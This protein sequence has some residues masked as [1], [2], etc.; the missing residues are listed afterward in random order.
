ME[1]KLG[2]GKVLVAIL[3][4]DGVQGV[5]FQ[6]LQ[7]AHSIGLTSIIWEKTTY[8]LREEDVVIWISKKESLDVVIDKLSE[9]RYVFVEAERKVETDPIDNE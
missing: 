4:K 5:L 8:V 1:I 6:P 3:K 7:E 2:E 9:M